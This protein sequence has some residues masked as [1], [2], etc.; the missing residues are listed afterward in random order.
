MV[1]IQNKKVFMSLATKCIFLLLM[2]LLPLSGHCVEP[3][4]LKFANQDPSSGFVSDAH[5][6]WAE[7]LEKRTGG[8]YR[9]EIAWSA[10]MGPLEAHY[11]LVR[12]GIAD[13]SFFT[14]TPP[15]PFNFGMIS[16]LPWNLPTAEIS[17]NAYW[18]L[19]KMGFFDREFSDVKPLF[20]WNGDNNALYSSKPIN[21]LD[22]LK[23]KKVATTIPYAIKFLKEI[24]ATPVVI[25][26][27]EVYEAIEKR[28][29]DACWFIWEGVIPF[30]LH[31]VCHYCI[32]PIFGNMQCAVAMSKYT[33]DKLP[34]DVKAIV[35]QLG[36]DV[37][38]PETIKGYQTA[39]AA[40]RK[41][42][43]EAGGV[44]TTWS[45][46]DLARM[47]K[48]ISPYWDEWI[49]DMEKKRH[50]ARKA[51]DAYWNILKNKG[52]ERPA[53]GYTPKD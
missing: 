35:D 22:D 44:V 49:K 38:L 18:D 4:S 19:Y 29:V 28:V 50:P 10:S 25:D 31:E 27:V 16:T 48:I 43:A 23:G 15:A 5:K 13:V 3:I 32:E 21:G 1:L 24:G 9:V 20:V 42:F 30:Q 37:L 33:Y 7:E 34:A 17:I 8:R 12:H 53:F 36:E 11:D 52:V 39:N 51:V 45:E 40:G 2:T 47:N 6:A 14:A 41:A 26:P 46:E